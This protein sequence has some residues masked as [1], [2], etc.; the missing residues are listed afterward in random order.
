MGAVDFP[1]FAPDDGRVTIDFNRSVNPPCAF[2]PFAT[3]LDLL[4]RTACLSQLRRGDDAAGA[5]IA[6]RSGPEHPHSIVTPPCLPSSGPNSEEVL[7]PRITS[8]LSAWHSAARTP[9]HQAASIRGPSHPIL[10]DGDGGAFDLGGRGGGGLLDQGKSPFVSSQM[11][12]VID[13][14]DAGELSKCFKHQ[15]RKDLGIFFNVLSA[16]I[17]K[18]AGSSVRDPVAVDDQVLRCL[19]PQNPKGPVDTGRTPLHVRTL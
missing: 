5:L 15:R 10:G 19:Q 2:T 18:R 12:G 8:T 1:G 11:H 6:P 9:E 14:F 13:L 3:C 17:V 16:P 4:S 7:R